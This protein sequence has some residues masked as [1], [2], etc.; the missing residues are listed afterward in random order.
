MAVYARAAVV[1]KRAMAEKFVVRHLVI[2]LTIMLFLRYQ[3]GVIVLEKISG[4]G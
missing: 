2:S 1:S 4:R 3:G